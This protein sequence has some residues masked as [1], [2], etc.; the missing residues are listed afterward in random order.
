MMFHQPRAMVNSSGAQSIETDQVLCA[1]K[2]SPCNTETFNP[3]RKSANIF[4][5]RKNYPDL[6]VLK[7]SKNIENSQN[8]IVDLDE[9]AAQEGQCHFA[10]FGYFYIVSRRGEPHTSVLSKYISR[11][12]SWF[13]LIIMIF[14]R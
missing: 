14:K 10:S 6:H 9:S 3:I 11:F 2:R 1:I 4:R 12:S 7:L 8:T 13:R 5:K